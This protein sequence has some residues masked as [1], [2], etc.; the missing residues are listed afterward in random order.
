MNNDGSAT[1]S[2]EEIDEQVICHHAKGCLDGY[3][4]IFR[5]VDED[6]AVISR[7][8]AL[9]EQPP[10]GK[11]LVT[12]EDLYDEFGQFKLWSDNIGVFATDHK[13]LDYRVR[14]ERDVKNGIVL[15]LQSL[16][17][18]LT[19]CELCLLLREGRS[20]LILNMQV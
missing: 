19:E 6:D 15:L 8:P 7:I 2:F 10:S 14:E 12:I 9:F 4:E 11:A 17:S 20:D 3:N 13:S 5:A 1:D 16:R 18:D